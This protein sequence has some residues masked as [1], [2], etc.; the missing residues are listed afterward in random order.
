MGFRGVET[1]AEA[2]MVSNP[3]IELVHNKTI[4]LLTNPVMSLELNEFLH[5]SEL[6]KR[7]EAHFD[8]RLVFS[9]TIRTFMLLDPSDEL[10]KLKKEMEELIDTS[11][12]KEGDRKVKFHVENPTVA[13]LYSRT[14][15]I[16]S[17]R[18][19]FS[20]RVSVTTTLTTTSTSSRDENN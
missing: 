11:N 17:I 19:M 13:V 14:D 7:D 1:T 20:S 16:Q 15:P 2:I 4:T 6:M 9:N 5:L 8:A 10:K 18:E 12:P 3:H